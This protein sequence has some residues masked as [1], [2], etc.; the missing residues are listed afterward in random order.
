MNVGTANGGPAPS[1]ERAGF[2]ALVGLLLAPILAQGAW[3]PLQHVF[4]PAGQAGMITGAALGV[5]AVH[6]FAA[7]IGRR[8]SPWLP[9]VA[10]GLSAVLLSAGLSLGTP[11]LLTLLIVAAAIASL[12]AWLPSRLPPTL[13]G[14]AAGHKALTALYLLVALSSVASVTKVSVFMGDPTQIDLQALPGEKFT[15][16]HSCLSAYVRALDLARQGVDNL[17]SDPWWFG[18][19]GLPPLPEGAADPWAPFGLDNFSYPPTFLLVAS[20]LAVLDGDFLAQ[21]AL[22]F[23]LNGLVGALGLWRV[24]Q[25]IGGRAAHRV[26]L[27]A[28]LFF[29]SLPVLL[30]LQIGNFHLAATALSLLAMVAFDRRRSAQGGALLAVAILSKISPGI[31][32][33]VLLV[34]RRAR[35]AALAAGFG[36]LVLAL[37]ALCFGL[38]PIQSFVSYALPRLSSGQAFPFMDTDAGIAT[39]MSPFGLPFKLKLLGLDIGEPWHRGPQFARAYTLGLLLLTIAGARRMGDRRDQAVRWMALLVL[40]SMQSPFCPAYSTIGL[41]WATTLLSVEV[42]RAWHAVALIALW[43]AILLVP[44]GLDLVPLAVLSMAHSALTIG[45]CAWLV[46]RA[47]PEGPPEIQALT[48]PIE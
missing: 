1:G 39:N 48:T 3:L 7:W 14:L 13:D 32:G 18:S 21:R 19:L 2:V 23:V 16:T 25:W 41:L 43:P 20:P 26:L 8:R 28:P 22:W 42:R 6:S 37:A 38:D 47:P 44:Q 29:G 34:Q 40:A 5:A 33:V 10:G 35:E 4:G 45:V 30:T 27:L 15:E 36:A 11:G 12:S 24:A 17:Y 31:L 46:L 9:A